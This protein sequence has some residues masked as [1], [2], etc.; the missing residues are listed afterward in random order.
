MKQ[1]IMPKGFKIVLYLLLFSMI[2]FA[3][4][5]KGIWSVCHTVILTDQNI[6]RLEDGQ[7]V[8]FSMD[9]FCVSEHGIDQTF[10]WAHTYFEY[11]IP[12]GSR[13]VLFDFYE[14][15]TLERMRLY[16]DGRGEAVTI[17]GKVT[18]VERIHETLYQEVLG[19]NYDQ[20]KQ[21][22]VIYQVT[23][24][25]LMMNGLKSLAWA[26]ILALIATVTLFSVGG[27]YRRKSIPFEESALYKE[28][29]FKIKYHLEDYLKKEQ[30]TLVELRERQA[31]FSKKLFLY[32]SLCVM[33]FIIF[34][35]CMSNCNRNVLMVYPMILGICLLWAGLRKIGQILLNMDFETSKRLAKA[36]ELQTIPIKM[37]QTSILIGLLK[38]RMVEKSERSKLGCG[39]SEE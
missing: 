20:L 26:G 5:I 18:R 7:I 17:M 39:E 32:I 15:D 30:E 25:E 9:S 31:S 21:G 10:G 12:I 6:D 8:E 1:N 13:Y 11:A 28:Y 27:I 23:K 3:M 19:E 24:E 35:V 2:A 38:R 34:G 16:V 36:F 33:G 14:K 22:F 29:R 4:F 37:E